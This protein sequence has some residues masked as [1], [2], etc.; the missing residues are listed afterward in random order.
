MIYKNCRYINRYPS[1]KHIGNE[2][3]DSEKGDRKK[4]T[5]KRGQAT[6]F[7]KKV[8]CPLFLKNVI[9]S[10]QRKRRGN[11]NNLVILKPDQPSYK[12]IKTRSR[13]EEQ[14]NKHQPWIGAEK[15]IEQVTK[16]KA[17]NGPRELNA[18]IFR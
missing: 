7:S 3:G 6:F 18:A 1:H 13:P 11:L 15:L 12:T 16:D 2:K 9:A 10:D 8:A 4:G 14:K 5:G 17:H